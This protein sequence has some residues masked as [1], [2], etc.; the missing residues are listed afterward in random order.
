MVSAQRL[1]T[2]LGQVTPRDPHGKKGQRSFALL[3]AE[4]KAQLGRNCTPILVF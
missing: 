2:D 4:D 1:M 3:P